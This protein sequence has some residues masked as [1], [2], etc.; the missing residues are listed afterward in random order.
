LGVRVKVRVVVGV[1]VFEAIAL[2]NTGFETDE[3][4]LLIP[5]NLLLEKNIDISELGKPSL[6]EYDT[7]GGSVTMYVYP[8]AC[9]VSIIEP[10]RSSREV[11]ADLVVSLTER[12][13]LMSDAL[14]EELGVIIISPR[15]GLWKFTDDP[16][17]TTRSSQRII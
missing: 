2:V 8:R 10:D 1:R 5:Y 11:I 7:P 17:T 6:L 13:V 12:E 4:Q 14:I 9:R 15:K 16:S 3:P